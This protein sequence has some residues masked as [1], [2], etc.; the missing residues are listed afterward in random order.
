MELVKHQASRKGWLALIAAIGTVGL[1]A[2]GLWYLG[3][4][5]ILASAGF[6]HGWWKH[7]ASWGMRF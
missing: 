5:G 4:L 3:V 1:F 2:T 6:A 7:R